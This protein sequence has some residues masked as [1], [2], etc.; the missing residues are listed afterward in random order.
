[1]TH[2]LIALDQGQ[3][4]P[5]PEKVSGF[6]RAM[7]P[8]SK[9]PGSRVLSLVQELPDAMGEAKKKNKREGTRF[10]FSRKGGPP[11]RL[12]EFTDLF[13]L[14]LSCSKICH[15][16]PGPTETKIPIF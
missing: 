7:R 3:T 8:I 5:V 10:Q 9:R 13:V 2:S 15:D 1:M 4:P 16:L 11:W 12:I 14:V 6:T